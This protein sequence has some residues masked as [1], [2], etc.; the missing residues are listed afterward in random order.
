MTEQYEF[1]KLLANTYA[2]VNMCDMITHDIRKGAPEATKWGTLKNWLETTIPVTCTITPK[3]LS[4]RSRTSRSKNPATMLIQANLGQV[5]H[6]DAAFVRRT[7]NSVLQVFEAGDYGLE[8]AGEA[9][10][11]GQQQEDQVVLS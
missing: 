11:D 9:D 7:A 8:G 5:M 6:D 4:V 3:G 1:L 2:P 10:A